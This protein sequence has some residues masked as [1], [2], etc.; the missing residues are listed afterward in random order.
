M[1]T[2]EV[3]SNLKIALPKHLFKPADR[4]MLLTEGSLLIIKKLEP[5]KLSSY[6]ARAKDRPLS[7]RDIDREVQ[8]YRRS[9]RA[10]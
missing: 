1:K 3:P 9:K 10:R 8:A 7:L 5:P 2:V 4:V 6:A